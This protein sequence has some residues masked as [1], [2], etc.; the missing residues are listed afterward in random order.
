M[1]NQEQWVSELLP[2]H[3]AHFDTQLLASLKLIRWVH[4]RIRLKLRAESIIK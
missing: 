2:G 4:R 1:Q 3:N